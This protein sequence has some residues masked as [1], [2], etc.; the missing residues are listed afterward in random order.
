LRRGETSAEAL[1]E[2]A[3]YVS[4]V[5]RDRLHGLGADWAEVTAVSAYTIHPVHALLESVLLDSMPI[6]RERGIHWHYARPPIIDIEFEMDL[7]G[8]VTE[9]VV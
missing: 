4:K 5:M 6:L 1:S 3:S 7:R 8:V 9:W 2:K